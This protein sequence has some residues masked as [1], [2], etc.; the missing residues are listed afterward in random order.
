MITEFYER[1][2]LWKWQGGDINKIIFS[3]QNLIENLIYL[4]KIKTPLVKNPEKVYHDSGVKY[5]WCV[6]FVIPKKM[7]QGCYEEYFVL[8]E[9][10]ASGISSMN[11]SS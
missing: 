10:G 1:G 9:L 8:S 5:M 11:S 4:I 3:K 6:I 2:I 7:E